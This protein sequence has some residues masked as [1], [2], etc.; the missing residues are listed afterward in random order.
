M[1][2]LLPHAQ[3]YALLF[4]AWVAVTEVIPYLGPWLGAIP[5]LIYALVVHPISALWVALLFLGIHQ[6]EGHVVVPKV[7]GNA[8]RLHP[9][10]VIF[11]LAAGTE[12][13]GLPGA[14][15]ALP[16]LAV[17]RAMWEF[18]SDRIRLEPWGRDEP[19]EDVPVGAR[20]APVTLLAA[21]GVAR[22][23]GSR[24]ALEPTDVSLAAG[25]VVAL[26]GPNGAGKSTLLSILAGS[27]EP[28]DGTVERPRARR[29]GAAARGALRPADGA[30]EPAP[31]RRARARAGR[32]AP[33]SSR[34]SSSCRPTRARSS[35][36]VGNRQRLDVALALLALAAGA[37]ARRA[38][39][40]ARPGAAR[41][42]LARSRAA[43]PRAAAR[44]RRDAPLGGARRASPTARSSSSKG[45]SREAGRCSSCGKD[46]RTL[47]RTPALL[48]VLL[49]YPVLI[50]ALLGL[51]AG[52]ANA[53]PRVALVDEDGLPAHIVVG[54]HTLRRRGDDRRGRRATSTLVHLDQD[55]AQRELADGKIVAVL[56]VPPGFVATLQQMVKSP[57]L[58]VAV[59]RGGTSG[60]VRQQV[61][62]LVYTLN[63]KLQR[64]YID[65]NLAVRPAAPARRRRQVPRP[66]AST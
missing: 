46:V 25:E 60:R 22:R 6:I 35:L 14:L 61:Q 56:T 9:L 15:I 53:K 52:Y 38:D 1:I 54:H 51:V 66:R 3:Q 13:Y 21:R 44:A 11:G 59:T 64:A 30:R 62:A 48:V 2:G 47:L 36:S 5:P 29:L 65:A 32:R 4:G 57:T 49:A 42:R 12:L 58:E 16:L 55:E 10:L 63:Q 39:V 31:V 34:P 33:T 24:V 28:T 40:V 18:F 45:G 20:R 50:A 19:A 8:L 7:M 17:G 43:S 23:F 26:V 37:A 41:A 27:L